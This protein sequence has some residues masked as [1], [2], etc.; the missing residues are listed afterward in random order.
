MTD[1]G[2]TLGVEEEYHLVDAVTM[3]LADRPEVVPEAVRLLGDEAQGEISTSQL[4]VATPVL[5]GLDQVRRELTRLRRGAD[6]A[7]QRHGCRILATGTHPF[8]SWHDQ[9]RTPDARYDEIEQRLGLLA[10]QQLIA[11]THV[12]VGV[13]DRELAVQVLDRMRP[14][15]PVL[16]ALSGSSPYWEGVDTAY[17][18]YRTQW[19]ARFPVTGSPEVLRDLAT[20]D[21]LVADLVTS[22]VAEDASHL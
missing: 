18:S 12:H 17:A 6:D 9:R 14:D 8:S 10:L 2:A 1:V 15:L 20:Y 22:G 4:E 5:T 11:G 21:R 3:G 19:F 13:P 7:A 16:L